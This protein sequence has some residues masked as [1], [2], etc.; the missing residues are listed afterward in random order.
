MSILLNGT[1]GITSP[2]IDSQVGDNTPAAG[3]FTDV[4]VSG[5]LTTGGGALSPQTGFKN[6]IING[7]M[8]ID[9][10]NDG[11][12]V[13]INTSSITYSVDRWSGFGMASA[14]VFTLN[15]SII[16]PTGFINSLAATCT[17]ADASIAAGDRYFINQAVEGLNIYDFGWGT[18]SA[19]TVTLSFWVQSSLTGTYCVTLLNADGSRSYVAEYTINTAD[20]WEYKTITISGDTSGTWLTT[21]GVGVFVRFALAIGTT[22]QTTANTWS[23]GN[24]NATANQVNWMS[25]SSSRTFRLSGVQLEKGSTA[26]PF[27]FRSIGTELGLCQRYYQKAKARQFIGVYEASGTLQANTIFPVQM[28]SDP[29]VTRL[30]NSEWGTVAGTATNSTA[31]IFIG[32]S[33]RGCIILPTTT[34]VTASLGMP[35]TCITSDFVDFSA[36]L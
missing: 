7:S 10:R 11:T 29:T 1:T 3:D 33:V 31:Y 19:Q 12:A 22:F 36:E 14:G 15:R 13:T 28:R 21:N 18:A 34:G 4:T 30:T 27:E 32:S 20:T 25:S 35:A 9:Q 23:A 16:A 5:T 8:T 26:T 24:F 17:T 2:N 6:R